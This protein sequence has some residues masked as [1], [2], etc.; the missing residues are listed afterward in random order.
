M[1]PVV[2]RYDIDASKIELLVN[3]TGRFVIG[4]PLADAGLTGRKIIVDTYGGMAR[5]GG[6]AFS[7]KDPSKVDRSASYALRWVAKN[8][9]AAKLARRC[10]L[11]VAYAIGRAHP[12]GLDVDTFGTGAVPD[13][14]IAQAI[15]TVADL[16][17][18]AIIERLELTSPVYSKATNYGHFGREGFTWE[19]TDLAEDLA[20][21]V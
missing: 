14:R 10:E 15:A 16:R 20:A 11:Q 5:H 6:G 9:V 21:A 2:A 8:I 18:A 13:K 4:G 17:P 3:P 19:R 12:V 1:D 7:G